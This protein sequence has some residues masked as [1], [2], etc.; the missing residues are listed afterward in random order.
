MKLIKQLYLYYIVLAKLLYFKFFQPVKK[1]LVEKFYIIVS[2]LGFVKER[3]A[4]T[5]LCISQVVPLT[6]IL[7]QL[8][9]TGDL[10]KLVKPVSFEYTHECFLFI[11]VVWV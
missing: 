3:S 9:L 8:V 11:I 7:V 6:L 1:K 5:I 4:K 10:V 2:C